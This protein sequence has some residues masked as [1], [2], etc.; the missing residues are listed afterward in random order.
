MNF[1]IES[2]YAKVDFSPMAV[3]FLDSII[4]RSS[5]D[6]FHSSERDAAV[7]IAKSFGDAP[8]DGRYDYDYDV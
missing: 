5:P 8:Y 7:S 2:V 6:H 3:G 1:D 4:E